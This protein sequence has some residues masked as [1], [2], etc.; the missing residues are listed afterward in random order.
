MQVAPS[1][2]VPA[3]MMWEGKGHL[4]LQHSSSCTWLKAATRAAQ[5]SIVLGVCFLF[6]F[7]RK[8][9]ETELLSQRDVGLNVGSSSY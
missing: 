9:N 3:R 4:K 2:K 1:A 6:A 8:K 5:H 7:L